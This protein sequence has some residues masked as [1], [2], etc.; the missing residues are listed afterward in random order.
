MK[1]YVWNVRGLN[2]LLK[3]KEVVSRIRRM[4]VKVVC[5]LET[6]VK[7]HK[8]QEIVE[9][10]FPGW[11]YLQ[12]YS[13]ARNGR[14]WMLWRDGVQVSNIV[15]NNQSNTNCIKY[16]NH[17]FFSFVQSMVAMRVWIV[18]GYGNI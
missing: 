9:K 14:I 2:H 8:M 12:N 1:I 15:I 3:Q 16:D 17:T 13:Y 5:L 10:W 7:E 4:K 6:S 18:E 11:S